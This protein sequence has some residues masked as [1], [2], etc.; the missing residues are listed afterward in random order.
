M[1]TGVPVEPQLHP[2]AWQVTETSYAANFQILGVVHAADWVGF[3]FGGQVGALVLHTPQVLI[4]QLP[5]SN[6]E[7]V[8]EET[9]VAPT[10]GLLA[11][12]NF[13]PGKV[14]LLGLGF[15]CDLTLT[16]VRRRVGSGYGGTGGRDEDA[17]KHPYAFPFLAV[18]VGARF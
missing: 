2:V 7:V 4:R 17:N 5:N 9:Q 8:Q 3:D 13:Y 16:S 6:I 10:A 15:G 12:V 1:T 18:R 14:L 11:G